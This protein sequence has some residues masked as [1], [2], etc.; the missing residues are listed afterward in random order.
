MMGI[1]VDTSENNELVAIYVFKYR[2]SVWGAFIENG[3]LTVWYDF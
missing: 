3:K 1:K 2:K